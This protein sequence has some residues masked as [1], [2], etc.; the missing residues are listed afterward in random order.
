MKRTV[1]VARRTLKVVGAI[2]ASVAAVFLLAIFVFVLLLV[3]L[4]YV[5]LMQSAWAAELARYSLVWLTF[6][7]IGVLVSRNEHPQIES[8]DTILRGV[9]TRIVHV[10]AN[11]AVVAVSIAFAVDVGGL[12]FDDIPTTTAVMRIPNQLAMLVPFIGFILAAVHALVRAFAVAVGVERG[13][14]HFGAEG[15][16][17]GGPGA[18]A[19]V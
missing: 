14:E 15:P 10:F 1:R 19:S 12:V 4:R 5:P 11:L 13:D 8:I 16:E 6:A 7:C 9:G 3:F 17:A 18:V 2:E